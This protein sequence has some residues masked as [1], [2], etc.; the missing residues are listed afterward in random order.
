M[1]HVLRDD[2]YSQMGSSVFGKI[3]K[4]NHIGYFADR[5]LGFDTI[6]SSESFELWNIS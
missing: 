2:E 3:A 5:L 4:R 1:I 6:S